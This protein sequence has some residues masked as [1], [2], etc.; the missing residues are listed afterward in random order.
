MNPLRL[1]P[2]ELGY[3]FSYLRVKGMIGWDAAAFQPPPGKDDAFYGEGRDRLLK[4]GLILKGK[5]PGRHRFEPGFSATAVA[6]TDPQ[7]VLMTMR[8]EGAGARTVNHYL[9]GAR[10]IEMRRDAEG[11]FHLTPV[12]AFAEAV[13]TAVTVAGA[14]TAG[15]AKPVRI[16]ANQK[17]FN[18]LRDLARAGDFAKA[19]PGLVKLGADPDAAQSVLRA[20]GQPAAAGVVTLL[21]CAANSV[22]DAET[23][24]VLTNAEGE[25]W[26]LFPPAGAD[27]PVVLE[28]TSVAA[29]AARILVSIS[30]RVLTPA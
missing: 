18:R 3:I 16:E 6:L 5:Q 9:S 19:V 21:Y 11:F 17:V 4:A 2:S 7:I 1:H 28:R 29:L 20:A 30:A 25:S 13:G 24:T 8:K 23:Y 22:K 15:V 26:V 12:S 14:G 10:V 27:G